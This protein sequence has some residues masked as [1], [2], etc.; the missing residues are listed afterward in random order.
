MV[1]TRAPTYTPAQQTRRRI[2]RNLRRFRGVVRKVMVIHKL[3]GFGKPGSGTP[4]EVAAGKLEL[5]LKGSDVEMRKLLDANTEDA[6]RAFVDVK[7]ELHEAKAQFASEKRALQQ[8][9]KTR[10]DTFTEEM[11]KSKTYTDQVQQNTQRAHMLLCNAIRWAQEADEHRQK[12]QR[13]LDE[14]QEGM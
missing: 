10:L 11:Q 2:D 1:R 7:E 9:V 13:A 4:R 12:A 3:T 6:V 8:L 5:R 14:I